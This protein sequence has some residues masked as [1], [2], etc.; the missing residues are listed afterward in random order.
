M[1]EQEANQTL[2]TQAR[3]KAASKS[4]GKLGSQL[5]DQKKQTRNDTLAAMSEEERRRRDMD[6][7]DASRTYN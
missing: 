1:Y 2:L 4:K 3:A 5:N 7:A 6:S